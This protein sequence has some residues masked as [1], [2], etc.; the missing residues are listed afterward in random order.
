LATVL[1]HDHGV[2]VIETLKAPTEASI[3]VTNPALKPRPRPDPLP[4][5]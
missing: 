3:G 1:P 2:A 4:G 5:F